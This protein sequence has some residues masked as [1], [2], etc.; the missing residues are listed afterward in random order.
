ML[1]NQRGLIRVEH[2]RHGSRA[3]LWLEPEIERLLVMLGIF[4]L[5]LIRVSYMLEWEIMTGR[6][7]FA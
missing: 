3:M 6:V 2:N 1:I 4:L 7:I 5:I